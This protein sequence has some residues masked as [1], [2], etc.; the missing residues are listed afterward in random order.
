MSNLLRRS[1]IAIAVLA[2][3]LLICDRL[4]PPPLAEFLAKRGQGS[5]IVL[6][7]SGEP[8]RAFAD[9]RG[10]WRYPISAE[11][12]SARYVQAL[13]NYEDRWFF[14]HPGV[15]PLAMLRAVAQ[16]AWYRKPI[17]GGST[18]SMQVA[19]MIE[20]IPHSVRGKLWQMA[21]A[22]Q[23]EARLSK[24][25]ILTL[26]LQHAPFGGPIEGV[27][28][29]SFAYLG[30]S[31]QQL[32]DAEAALLVVLPQ[33]PS[34][35]RP[36]RHALRAQSARD[37]VLRRLAHFGVLSERAVNAALQE[38]VVARSL[39]TPMQAA[40]FAERMKRRYVQQQRQAST[41]S[42]TASH[43]GL[44]RA[45]IDTGIKMQWQNMLQARIESAI[46]RY[47]ERTSA[48]ALIVDN[49][50]M[51]VRAYVGS[52]RFG[53]SSSLGHIDMVRAQR[54][55]GSTLKPTLYA[56]AIDSG[57]IHSES[58]LIDAPQNF[59]GYRPAN[60][61]EAFN[62]PVSAAAALRLSLNVPAV[63]LLDRY[64]PGK[65][66]GALA[67]AGLELQLPPGA[68]PNLSLIL[69]G[70]GASL[71]QLVGLHSALARGG[72]SAAPRM[73]QDDPL[74][75]RY[76]MSQGAAWIA[77]Q[78]LAA[79]QRK[80]D[81]PLFAKARANI[82]YKTGTSFGFRDAWALGTSG[83]LTIGVWIGRPDG[84]PV[85]GSFGAASALPLLFDV[86]DA[87]PAN[88]I[89]RVP[90]RPASVTD[91]D[92]CW[93]LGRAARDTPEPLCHRKKQALILADAIPP[94]LPER[95]VRLWQPDR[96][97]ITLDSAGQR[98]N[99]SCISPDSQAHEL[100]RWP[101]LAYPWLSAALR[102]QSD[103]PA[104]AKGCVPDQW[105]FNPLIIE[106]LHLDA[107]LRLPSNR[108]STDIGVRVVGS[109]AAIRWLL[110][111]RA[112]G[113]SQGAQQF[114]FPMPDVGRYR[115]LALEQS[116]R[117]AA[118]EFS[119]ER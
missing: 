22:L 8:L 4:F 94:T 36:D 100:A 5:V 10:I 87:L 93:P 92:I 24:Q 56:L 81:S 46:R 73:Q 13:L 109:D 42:A 15:N 89:G 108:A 115:L 41:H 60:F 17:S 57:L 40:L 20:P 86:F 32:S 88:A 75:N 118:V 105:V 66:Y 38:S 6:A 53:D 59:S 3:G 9:P 68:T 30:K 95:D 65:F 49:Q 19:R 25:D 96:V 18:L 70:G 110:N 11:Q 116:G 52:A 76:V 114:V 29:A 98:R 71:E 101:V 44:K 83:N 58:L 84:T 117:Y 103:M 45:R 48:A 64:G 54:S 12:T 55:P 80:D 67:N 61:S 33:R 69:G 74:E 62:G 47:P 35:L 77:F 23:L 1:L 21:R 43:A 51:L 2:L 31:S 112:I 97:T 104:L 14:R 113:E 7:E 111:D 16:A 27:E 37:K 119:V 102:G 99:A 79:Q 107:R 28:A 82:A 106:G 63:D 50:S 34:A 90:T 78:M 72:L 91:V 85:P 26:Y 39:R